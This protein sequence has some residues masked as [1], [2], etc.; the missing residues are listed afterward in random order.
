MSSSDTDDAFPGR[1]PLASAQ[2]NFLFDEIEYPGNSWVSIQES[3]HLP[4]RLSERQ[5]RNL[6]AHVCR[7]SEA[8]RSRVVKDPDGVFRQE[9]M[10]LDDFF[11]HSFRYSDSARP[12]DLLAQC[13]QPLDAFTR[14]SFFLVADGPAGAVVYFAVHHSFFDGVATGLLGRMILSAAADPDILDASRGDG[15]GEAGERA[16]QPRQVR[17]FEVDARGV[18]STRRWL[19]FHGTVRGLTWP[20]APAGAP[21]ERPV[22]GAAGGLDAENR[23]SFALGGEFARALPRAAAEL[24]VSA[25]SLINSLVCGCVGELFGLREVTLKTICSNRFRPVLREALACLATEVWAA[26]GTEGSGRPDWHRRFHGQLLGAYR[27]GMYDWDAVRGSANFPG[28]YRSGQS[29]S[30]NVAYAKGVRPGPGAD[31]TPVFTPLEP[32]LVPRVLGH[33][34]AVHAVIGSRDVL[35]MVKA[36][37]HRMDE[38]A[39]LAFA[40]GLCDHFTR[41]L[42]GLRVAP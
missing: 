41:S 36:A 16:A 29:V 14:S 26:R 27:S 18:R 13:P 31:D 28:P 23:V 6:L 10:E 37:A 11:A 19:G 40:R 21:A 42:S 34:L 32:L 33:E 12:Q 35:F 9:I 7:R 3:V 24:G 4:C 30:T 15:P 20:G 25:P 38:A 5:A 22:R 2:L 1:H 8:V 39:A 17:A